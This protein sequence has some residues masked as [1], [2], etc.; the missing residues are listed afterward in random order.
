[1]NQPTHLPL[2]GDPDA[3]ALSARQALLLL[4]SLDAGAAPPLEQRL[5]E[6]LRDLLLGV[7][8][9]DPADFSPTRALMDYGLDSIASTEIGTLFTQRFGISV[10]PTVFFEFQNLQSFCGYLLAN[11]HG[12]LLEHYGDSAPLPAPAPVV[13][14]A[15]PMAQVVAPVAAGAV[16]TPATQGPLS[17]EA[18]W[19]RYE[20]LAPAAPAVVQGTRVSN[21]YEPSQALLDEQFS[22]CQQ[23]GRAHV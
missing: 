2:T 7:L 15:P 22:L 16:A 12:Q 6:D 10:P 9:I 1:M 18:L 8:K 13:A 21:E 17:I 14:A 4:D 11:H 23:I 3:G 5:L 20:H 19:Q